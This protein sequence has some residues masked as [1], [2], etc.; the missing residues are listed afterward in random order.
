VVSLSVF[1]V[2][3][4]VLDCHGDDVDVYINSLQS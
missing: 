2:L 3:F 4:A 1:C